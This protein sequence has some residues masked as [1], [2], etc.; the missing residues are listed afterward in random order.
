[1]GNVQG[2][3]SALEL[4]SWVA[5][6]IGGTGAE[7]AQ[8]IGVNGLRQ[9]DEFEGGAEVAKVFPGG[10]ARHEASGPKKAGVVV[11]GEQE[12]LFLV[13][14][15]PLMNGAVVLPKFSE[16]GTPKAAVSPGLALRSGK[17]IG[18]VSFD[19]GLDGGAGTAQ[20]V[21]AQQFIGNELK[22]WRVLEGEELA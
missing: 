1:M 9:A 15:P 18:E 4:A 3:Q 22:I 2:A 6:I 10:V 13:G 8:A 19:V 21:K 14:G 16:P 12:G 5:I 11:N 17:Q 20:A 7:K